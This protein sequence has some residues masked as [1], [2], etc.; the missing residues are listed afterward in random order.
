MGDFNAKVGKVKVET[1]TGSFGLGERNNRGDRLVEFCQVRDLMI[2]NTF[3]K[4]T[5]RRLYTWKSPSPGNTVR[6]QID[7]IL[8]NNRYKNS[9]IATKTYPGADINS[10]H[11]PVIAKLNVKMKKITKRLNNYIDPRLLR[12][13]KIHDTVKKETNECMRGITRISVDGKWKRIQTGLE[14]IAKK[15]LIIKRTKKK[16]WITSEILDLIKRLMFK[17][18]A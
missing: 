4:L 13:P 8:I 14:T 12:D 1:H 10:D 6:N 18:L 9:I 11:N 5:D 7:Y 16:P 17:M 2:T 15:H 3:F